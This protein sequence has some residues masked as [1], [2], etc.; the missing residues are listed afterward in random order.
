MR[1]ERQSK[2][3]ASCSNADGRRITIRNQQ[4]SLGSSQATTAEL[5]QQVFG[6]YRKPSKKVR[7]T[8]RPTT[9][10]LYSGIFLFVMSLV[11]IG[12]QPPQKVESVANAATTSHGASQPSVDSLVATNVAAGIAERADLPIASNVA[13]L[14]ISLTAENQLAQTDTNV[15]TKPQIVQPTADSREVIHYTAKAGDTVDKIARQ[16]GVSAETIRW[17]NDL[18]SDA[19]EKGK[20]LIIPPV[21]GVIYTV[22]GGDSIDTIA[23]KYS[24]DKDRIIAF[25]DLELSGIKSGQKII[26]PGG[27]M[28]ET[29]ANNTATPVTGGSGVGTGYSSGVGGVNY[30]LAGASAGNRYAPNNCTWYAYERRLQ[31]G[32]PIGSFWGNASTW[33]M[34]ASAAGYRV[35]GSPEA[36]AVMQNGGG[37]AGYGHVAVVEQVVQGQYVRVS[38]MNAYRGGGGYGIVSNFDVP[39]SEAVSGMYLY[40]H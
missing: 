11:A 40:I 28:P 2:V 39:W 22:Q 31:L 27:D 15:I 8:L 18:T 12:Y 21:D 17:A 23:S 38:E 9:I 32:R 13:N 30:Q 34:Y 7:G 24:A 5:K 33:A 3:D 6:R 29:P 25:N 26:I 20:K 4:S 16:F 36:G 37:Y 35:D 19:L 10:A 1:E 14:S